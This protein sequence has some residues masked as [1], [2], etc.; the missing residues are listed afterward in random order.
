MF[1]SRIVQPE[2]PHWKTLSREVQEYYVRQNAVIQ[3]YLEVNRRF[4]GLQTNVTKEDVTE[5]RRDALTTK[6]SNGV[7][8]A[9]TI[10]KVSTVTKQ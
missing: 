3:S 6:L 10:G 9:L 1:A 7:N 5:S 8:I 2:T 4:D